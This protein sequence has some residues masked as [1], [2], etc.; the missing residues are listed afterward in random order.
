M[1]CKSISRSQKKAVPC[2]F[3]EVFVV[4]A[5]GNQREVELFVRTAKEERKKDVFFAHSGRKLKR[6]IEFL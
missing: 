3:R 1:T 2:D 6:S 5:P 4:V